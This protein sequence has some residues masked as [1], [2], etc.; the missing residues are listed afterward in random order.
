MKLS[1]LLSI[2]R[3]YVIYLII[4]IAIIDNRV[5]NAINNSF[6]VRLF[7]NHNY[8]T[9]R[10]VFHN[11]SL[12]I[13]HNYQSDN[14]TSEYCEFLKRNSRKFSDGSIRLSF[15]PNRKP[16]K[17]TVA[18]AKL[19]T[20][21]VDDN[22]YLLTT[23][24]SW[25]PNYFLHGRRSVVIL[26]DYVKYMLLQDQKDS[27]KDLDS[28]YSNLFEVNLGL[29]PACVEI[30]SNSSY[31][32]TNISNCNHYVNIDQGYRVYSYSGPTNK[33][34]YGV[35]FASVYKFPNPYLSQLYDDTE[36]GSIEDWQDSCFRGH[37]DFM[38]YDDS[39][40][41]CMNAS[42]FNS[43]NIYL[44]KLMPSSDTASSRSTPKAY[45]NRR[46]LGGES[47][48]YIKY[49]TWYP[50]GSFHL[51]LIDYFDYFMKLD[52]D[53]WLHRPIPANML[54]HM[55]RDGAY[56]ATGFTELTRDGDRGQVNETNAYVSAL[57]QTCKL[58]LVPAFYPKRVNEFNAVNYGN[59]MV[60][61]LGFFTSPQLMHYSRGWSK[62]SS[63]FYHRWG[64][65]QYW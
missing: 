7:N 56:L 35:V 18:N 63:M 51:D 36:Y 17:E 24:E 21:L 9:K 20:V 60:T 37:F 59:F 55:A 6:S 13:K 47:Y 29:T 50:H 49:N 2:K 27:I 43:T 28:F 52:S 62:A 5:T 23:W 10:I 4:F 16:Q 25:K 14:A 42:R 40:S 32:H 57:G 22:L 19:I 48:T 33:S 11:A 45:R 39:L 41:R 3:L 38:K 64:D 46:Q 65:Q 58:K 15:T 53:I 34:N 61:W 44:S 26:F 30:P 12:G 54:T 31:S 8:T 1:L